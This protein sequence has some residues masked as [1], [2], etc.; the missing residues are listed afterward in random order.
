MRLCPAYPGNP[1]ILHRG[2]ATSTKG[3]YGLVRVGLRAL[4]APCPAGR[5]IRRDLE[6]RSVTSPPRTSVECGPRWRHVSKCHPPHNADN[7]E[8]LNWAHA[9]IHDIDYQRLPRCAVGPAT[10]EA[11]LLLP[12]SLIGREAGVHPSHSV[13]RLLTTRL[14]KHRWT[15]L[16]PFFADPKAN[17]PSCSPC[18]T[19]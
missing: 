1:R 4:R 10:S 6:Y 8:S 9:L 14:R 13:C 18:P 12:R 2:W 15:L 7:R 19:V 3:T 11:W 5:T 16:H 17:P